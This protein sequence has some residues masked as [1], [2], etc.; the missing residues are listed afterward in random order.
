MT[1][2]WTLAMGR[3]DFARIPLA[4]ASTPDLSDGEVRLRVDRVG[5]SANNVTYAVLGTGQ[6]IGAPITGHTGAVT[7]VAFSPDGHRLASANNDQ[8]VRLWPG[9]VAGDAVRQTDREHEPSAVAR[10]GV[11]PHRLHHALPGTANPGRCL[12]LNDPSK[13]RRV[14]QSHLTVGVVGGDTLRS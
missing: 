13:L 8:T 6:P 10:L 11:A 1:T 12:K 5:L 9:R 4:Y 7:G 14:A 3:D 2:S